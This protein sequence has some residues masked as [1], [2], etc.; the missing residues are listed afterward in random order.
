VRLWASANTT[1]GSL[2]LFAGGLL[3]V[4][5]IFFGS[6][7]GVFF[8]RLFFLFFIHEIAFV[9]EARGADTIF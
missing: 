8:C 4:L 9:P 6:R 7:V 1:L 3:G 5:V 2:L